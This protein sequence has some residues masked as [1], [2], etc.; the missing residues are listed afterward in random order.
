MD[1][2]LSVAVFFMGLSVLLCLIRVI[3]GPTKGD[4]MIGINVI[5]TKTLVM[6]VMIAF[7]MKAS[8]F[9]DVA[10]V[11]AL[12]GFVTSVV[13]SREISGGGNRE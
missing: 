9:V 7:L 10:L 3:I 5:A 8:Y 1:K 2:V 13:V 11:Y 6:I 12:I 4:R